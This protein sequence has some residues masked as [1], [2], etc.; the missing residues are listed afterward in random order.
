MAQQ[1]IILDSRR[2][3]SEA[4]KIRNSHFNQS[5][6]S[7]DFLNLNL[8]PI[9][10]RRISTI[11]ENPV[12]NTIGR[13]RCGWVGC[14]IWEKFY[15]LRNRMEARQLHRVS[16]SLRVVVCNSTFPCLSPYYS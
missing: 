13:T 10:Y 16:R 15:L 12:R 3:D 4:L 6:R 11:P 14:F 7:D 2:Y 5:L 9:H 8:I 1:T